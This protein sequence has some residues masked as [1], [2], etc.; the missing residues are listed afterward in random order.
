MHAKQTAAWRAISYFF[1]IEI[2]MGIV[3]RR[4]KAGRASGYEG[5]GLALY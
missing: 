3:K 1:Q 2:E 4:A 5:A